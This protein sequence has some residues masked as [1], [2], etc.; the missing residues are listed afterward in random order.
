MVYEY[1]RE[2]LKMS[3]HLAS[4]LL[5]TVL[6]C[7]GCTSKEEQKETGSNDKVLTVVG[8]GA[9]ESILKKVADAFNEQNS[10]LKAV[11]PAS[12]GSSGGIKAVGNGEYTFGRVARPIKDK[13]AH[14]NLSYLPF[15]KDMVLFAGGSMAGVKS[16]TTEQLV[17]I[18]TG[19]ITDWQDVGGR[20]GPIRVLLRDPSDSTI[21]LIQ[22]KIKEF[23]DIDFTTDARVLNHDY[24]MVEKLEKYPTAI[25]FL[26][27]GNLT[28][29]IIPIA[30]DG[31]QPNASNV[32]NNTYTLTI[33]YA[34]IYKDKISDEAGEFINYLFSAAGGKILHENGL[35]ALK[36]K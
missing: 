10:E 26:T 17:E 36:N 16:L 4:L 12:I 22:K 32:L 3:C 33:E 7:I 18:F 21:S 5:L 14:Y 9:C 19:T 20:P 30:I 11:I 28:D 24:E 6:F 25:G 15:A 1:V 2:S 35:I 31:V 27:G 34:F 29:K 13:E 8:T 23:K